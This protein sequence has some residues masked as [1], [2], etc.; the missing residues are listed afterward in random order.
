MA[1]KTDPLATLYEEDITVKDDPLE[2]LYEEKVSTFAS[3]FP[4]YQAPKL[5][6]EEIKN[7]KGEERRAYMEQLKTEQELRK[8]S[9]FTKGALSG[10]TIGASELI[11]GLSTEG[12]EDIAAVTTGEL[13]GSLAP[14]GL[15][16][17]GAT[18]PLK[19]AARQSPIITRGLTAAADLLGTG[20]AGAAYEGAKETIK[21][22]LPTL[23]DV[24]THGLTW[25]ALDAGLK[26]LGK[27]G[28]FVSSLFKG[29]KEAK[30]APETLLSKV[31]SQ[32]EKEGID[33]GDTETV[34]NVALDILE[35]VTQQEKNAASLVRRA[36]KTNQS[37]LNLST[38]QD[39][40]DTIINN[41]KD[42]PDNQAQ[43]LI[44]EHLKVKPITDISENS[45]ELTK[46]IKPE[47]FDGENL[48]KDTFD[49]QNKK[50]INDF[51]PPIENNFEFGE[52]VKDEVETKYKIAK[53][54]YTTLYN[55]VRNGAAENSIQVPVESSVAKSKELKN[56]ITRLKTQPSEYATVKRSLDTILEDLNHYLVPTKFG[57]IEGIT[58]EAIP[59]DVAQDL[60][61]RIG[62]IINYEQIE[63]SIKKQL[64]PI[65]RELKNQIKGSLKEYPLISDQYKAAEQLY[66]KTAN[67][68]GADSVLKIRKTEAPEEIAKSF[69]SP[70]SL[71]NIKKVVSEDAYKQIESQVLNKLNSS[72]F[73]EAEK[74]ISQVGKDLSKQARSVA[75]EIILRKNPLNSKAVHKDA[76]NIIRQDL[77]TSI[78]LGQRPNKALDFWKNKKTRRL[79]EESLNGVNNRKDIINFLNSQ[80]IDDAIST[81]I[82]D[83]GLINIDKLNKFLKNK[84]AVELLKDASG[85]EGVNALRKFNKMQ[86]EFKTN[87]KFQEMIPTKFKESP[88]GK[89]KI[90]KAKEK[91]IE[92]LRE[93]E[94]SKHPYFTKIDESIAKLPTELK[95]ALHAVGILGGGLPKYATIYGGYYLLRGI[96]KNPRFRQALIKSYN[97]PSSAKA[98]ISLIDATEQLNRS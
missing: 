52:V 93:F 67:D 81:F 37:P 27:G 72:S 71:K 10:L 9:G 84:N 22:N 77:A 4:Q 32:I 5:S 26:L 42:T 8:S 33:L 44:L 31:A 48:L 30:Q 28:Q 39:I 95:A 21:G 65:Y 49:Q 13:S 56:K 63:P 18:Y 94:K 38:D 76:R 40:Q 79:V 87:K 17:K 19:L 1:P 78:P 43:D 89:E 7:L 64:K 34:G 15:A 98:L 96:M 24:L 45:I 23:D 25:T 97:H 59:F 62:D 85:P 51:E 66:A 3:Q 29:S 86:K 35:D 68:Y 46:P 36:K 74:L 54:E 70:S 88:Y 41:L 11:P 14:I 16:I 90:T 53:D 83:T 69:T 55:E 60:S 47:S 58:S 73:K 92:R 82:D 75:D 91:N 12:E 20:I 2:G 80:T 6:S 50:L 57:T 61:I